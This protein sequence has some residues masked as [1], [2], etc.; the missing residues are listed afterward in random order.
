M[1]LVGADGLKAEQRDDGDVD[2]LADDD[3]DQA[4]Q[5]GQ[6][7]GHEHHRHLESGRRHEV[8][9]RVRY[10]RQDGRGDNEQQ[11]AEKH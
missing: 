4:R 8:R 3:G 11:I 6:K 2:D 7:T 10:G 5:P 1:P 9:R